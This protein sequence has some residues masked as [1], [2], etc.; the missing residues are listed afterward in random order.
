MVLASASCTLSALL[1]VIHTRWYA[2]P[3]RQ[4]RTSTRYL[5]YD[6]RDVAALVPLCVAECHCLAPSVK[7]H[8]PST[9][10]PIIDS[11]TLL[12]HIRGDVGGSPILC[13]NISRFVVV[14]HWPAF[15]LI[16]YVWCSSLQP[17]IY[18]HPSFL[19]THANFVRTLLHGPLERWRLFLAEMSPAILS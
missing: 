10:H 13:I 5:R 19:T 14:S 9:Y 16:L 8:K 1:S 7:L 3:H 15:K 12:R 18:H 17:R 2:D 6:R 4:D 11:F